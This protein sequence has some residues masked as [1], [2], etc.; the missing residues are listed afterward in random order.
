MPL[1]NDTW[2]RDSRHVRPPEMVLPAHTAPLDITFIG[3]REHHLSSAPPCT[4]DSA[5][6]S[7]GRRGAF[8]CEWAGDAL[9]AQHGSWNRD[10]PAGFAVVRLPF[11]GG[12]PSGTIEPLLAHGGD[13]ARWPTGFRPVEAEF[14]RQGRLLVSSDASNEIVR[15]EYTDAT[16]TS[17]SS[18]RPTPSAQTAAGASAALVA[19]AG[20]VG[21]ALVALVALLVLRSM[22]RR[23]RLRGSS[24]GWVRDGK[25]G[26]ADT[27]CTCTCSTMASS[28]V[29]LSVE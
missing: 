15:I 18:D 9:V 2:C 26:C 6:S 16:G 3:V 5:N 12:G 13:G 25:R 14:D 7:S 29:R 28:S 10:T 4:A 24:R 22:G 1:W 11:G 8:P 20:T 19:L 17:N 27:E 21:G 23:A